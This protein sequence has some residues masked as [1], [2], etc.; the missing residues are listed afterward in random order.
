[1]YKLEYELDEAKEKHEIVNDF[2]RRHGDQ[3]DEL[4]KLDATL[5]ESLTRVD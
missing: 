1:M 3:R 4:S 5:E 2:T